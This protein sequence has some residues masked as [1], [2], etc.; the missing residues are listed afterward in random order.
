MKDWQLM[1]TIRTG[2]YAF[3]TNNAA[4]FSAVTPARQR[5]LFKVLI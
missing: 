5:D 4:D 2:D 1:D 3:V